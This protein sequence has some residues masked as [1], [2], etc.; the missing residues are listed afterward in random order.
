MLLHEHVE[1]AADLRKCGEVL[2][3]VRCRRDDTQQEL[4]WQI[5]EFLWQIRQVSCSVW[6]YRCA[7]DV[8][9]VMGGHGG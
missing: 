7:V 3:G 9:S 4:M 1:G 2:R 6:V 8:V 5:C